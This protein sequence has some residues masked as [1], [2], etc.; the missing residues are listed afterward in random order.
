MEKKR[1]AVGR[2][3]K[4]LE[5]FSPD[6]PF[7][8]LVH[9]T[10]AYKFADIYPTDELLP[11]PCPVFKEDLLYFFYG[12]PA[13]RVRDTANSDIEFNWPII[14][15]F[16]P[17][18]IK[19]LKRVFPFDTG[20]FQRGLYRE[21]FHKDS[22]L[23]DFQLTDGLESASRIVDG[24]YSNNRNYYRGG[25]NKNVEIP[26]MQFEA[27]GVQQLSRLPGAQ[28]HPSKNRRD[29]RSSAIEFQ[30]PQI[31]SFRAGLRAIVLPQQY[32]DVEAVVDALT[33]WA[34]P[35]R[36]YYETLH[37]QSGEA[38]VGQIYAKVRDIYE[39]L[40]YFSEKP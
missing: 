7:L 6:P 26:L 30:T 35:V 39:E 17:T 8:P 36:R 14:F 18:A 11:R 31:V 10:T 28:I 27:S 38:W 3:Q 1:A 2:F 37:N 24:F 12:R 23:D 13:Y 19:L 9:T 33:R 22:A 32:L 4:F 16:D 25:S 34:V 5:Q 29:E 21:F 15:I 40:G 20:G